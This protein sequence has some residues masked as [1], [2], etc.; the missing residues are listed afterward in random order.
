MNGCI[1]SRSEVSCVR[2]LWSRLQPMTTFSGRVQMNFIDHRIAVLPARKQGATRS[3][4][5]AGN[6]N[7]RTAKMELL[8]CRLQLSNCISWNSC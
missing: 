7:S 1:A 4:T 8:I 5:P 3:Y 6:R 2:G